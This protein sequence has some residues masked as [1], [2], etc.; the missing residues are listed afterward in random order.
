MKKYAKPALMI[1]LVVLIAACAVIV[2]RA[3]RSETHTYRVMLDD[4]KIELRADSIERRD[5]CVIFWR[6]GRVDTILC[7][8]LVFMIVTEILE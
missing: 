4:K 8:P 6:H 7:E 1:A 5:G 2:D 3:L